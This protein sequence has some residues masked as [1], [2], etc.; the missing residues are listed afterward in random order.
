M[1]A[2]II[3]ANLIKQ[4][5]GL[6]LTPYYCPAGHKTIGYGHVITPQ[7]SIGNRINKQQAE[8]L[9]EDD[10]RKCQ[11]ALHKYCSVPLTE[12]Q[13]AALISFI[14]N[15]GVGAFQSSTLRQRLNRGEYLNAAN[16]LLRWIHAKGVKLPGLVERREIE[17]SLFLSRINIAAN[18][19][20]I[21]NP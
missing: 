19:G 5:E 8:E 1:T 13:Q 12:N 10:I 6:R 18:I 7:E 11:T 4:F 2:I 9:L 15:C 17:Q 3:A 14:F 16:E 21:R 20:N